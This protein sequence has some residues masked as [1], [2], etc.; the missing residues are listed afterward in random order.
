M[1]GDAGGPG[2]S[3]AATVIFPVPWQSGQVIESYR[4]E[5]GPVLIVPETWPC[6][7]HSLHVVDIASGSGS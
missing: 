2:A 1:H 4:H 7:R 3:P 5:L 6:P